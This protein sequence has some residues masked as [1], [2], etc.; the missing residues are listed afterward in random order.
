MNI[1]TRFNVNDRVFC[2]DEERQIF[3]KPCSICNGSGIVM[4]KGNQYQCPE[5][6]GNGQGEY[7]YEYVS[8]SATINKIVISISKNGNI[9]ISYRCI[10]DRDAGLPKKDKYKEIPIAEYENRIFGSLEEAE[11]HCKELNGDLEIPKLNTS[12]LGSDVIE[13]TFWQK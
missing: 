6:A 7:L 11:T 13:E 8:H 9:H 10:Y 5:C 3:R 1:K 2:I 4:L 12:P